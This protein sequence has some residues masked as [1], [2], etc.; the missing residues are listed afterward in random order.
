MLIGQTIKTKN[1]INALENYQKLNLLPKFILLLSAKTTVIIVYFDH[2]L[3]IYKW[4]RQYLRVQKNLNKGLLSLKC[5]TNFMF[6][7][8]KY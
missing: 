4:Y 5:P 7:E 6:S 8:I 1:I 2:F 3:G